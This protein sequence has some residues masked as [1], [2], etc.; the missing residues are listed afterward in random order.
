MIGLSTWSRL[1]TWSTATRPSSQMSNEAMLPIE[2][3]SVCPSLPVRCSAG[4]RVTSLATAHRTAM[5]MSQVTTR[6]AMTV[7]ALMAISA[8][9]MSSNESTRFLPF[10]CGVR[11]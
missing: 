8:Q 1:K 11:S 3:P 2:L 6:I 5:A 7:T 9:L 10:D 4:I